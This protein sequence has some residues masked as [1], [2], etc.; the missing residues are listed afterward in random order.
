MESLVAYFIKN[1]W[2]GTCEKG[3]FDTPR[4]VWSPWRRK[5]ITYVIALQATKGT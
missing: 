3:L 1:F 2:D 4:H 5:I